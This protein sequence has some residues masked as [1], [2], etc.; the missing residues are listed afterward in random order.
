LLNDASPVVELVGTRYVST[1]KND[2]PETRGL[3]IFRHAGDADH[4]AC[5]GCYQ[6]DQ[7]A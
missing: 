2:V 6:F 1:T 3:V 7:K 5:I 4:S